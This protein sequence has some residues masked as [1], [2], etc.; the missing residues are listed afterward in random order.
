MGGLIYNQLDEI[1][2][3]PPPPPP[4]SY[5][6]VVMANLTQFNRPNRLKE[7]NIIPL[8]TYIKENNINPLFPNCVNPDV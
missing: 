1:C 3:P 6:W 7:N 5:N 8:Q 2:Y 4:P